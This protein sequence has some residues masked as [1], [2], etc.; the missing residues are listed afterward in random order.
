[1]KKLLLFLFAAIA[2]LGLHAEKVALVANSASYSGEGVVTKLSANKKQQKETVSTDAVTVEFESAYFDNSVIRTYSGKKITITPAAGIKVTAISFLNAQSNYPLSLS[3]NIGSLNNNNWTGE[4]TNAIEF[5]HTTSKGTQARFSVLEITY[6][7]EFSGPIDFVLPSEADV[8]LNEK[9][10]ILPEN[11][12]ANITWT[13]ANENIATVENGVITGISVGST[14][15]TASWEPSEKWNA[16]ST[17][18]KVTVSDLKKFRQV[19]SVD[20]LELNKYYT[21]GCYSASIAASN[22]V[23]AKSILSTPVNFSQN[24]NGRYEFFENDEMLTFSLIDTK[25]SGDNIKY[26]IKLL[27]YKGPEEYLKP[28][29]KEIQ[30][31]TSS[32]DEGY[33][34]I[35]FTTKG[36]VEIK[37]GNSSNAILFNKDQN[38]FRIYATSS[39][40][41]IQL[42]KE[43]EPTVQDNYRPR[44]KDQT[45]QLG[46]Q[47]ST[48]KINLGLEGDYPDVT[49][50]SSDESVATVSGNVVTAKGVGSA[51]ITGSWEES[52]SW[53]A[54]SRAFNVSVIDPKK[55][56]TLTFQHEIIHGKVGVGVAAQAAIYDG[57]GVIT[58]ESSNTSAVTV[59]TKTGMIRPNDVKRV[60]KVFITA[61]ATGTAGT[62]PASA[63]YILY[64]DAVPTATD[65]ENATFDFTKNNYG[66][67]EFT[68]ENCTDENNIEY[69]EATVNQREGV[70]HNHVMI[71]NENGIILN[72]LDREDDIDGYR[73]WKDLAG[74]N[75]DEVIN[76]L[77]LYDCHFSITAP[78]G[79]TLEYIEFTD[80]SDRLGE[81][82][83]DCGSFSP[84]NDDEDAI[85]NAGDKAISS[86]E[87]AATGKETHFGK[88]KVT[89]R[90]NT[91]GMKNPNLTFG[92]RVYS[93]TAGDIVEV[94]GAETV[95]NVDINYSI[96]NTDEN[97]YLIEPEA[98]VLQIMLADPG[99][100][101]L[102]AT[103]EATDEYVAGMAIARIDVFPAISVEYDEN[104]ADLTE[105]VL[106]LPAEGGYVNFTEV[107]GPVSLLVDEN[108]GNGEYTHDGSDFTIEENKDLHLTYTPQYAET[109]KHTT[110]NHLYVYTV[111]AI[112]TY[113]NDGGT[114]HTYSWPEGQEF[115][116]QLSTQNGEQARAFR[117]NDLDGWTKAEGNTLTIDTEDH[118]LAAG[119][120]LHINTKTVKQTINGPIET[121]TYFNMP[122]E[123]GMSGIAGVETDSNADVRYFNLEGVEMHGDLAPGLYIR[124]T[125][126]NAQKVNVK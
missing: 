7:E 29:S 43:I 30:K 100:Y 59:D 124:L 58:Y 40:Q 48:Y 71:V 68:S 120:M 63:S 51:I 79:C 25:T 117:A 11:H 2:T 33:A 92:E 31:S 108:D 90:D 14:N 95:A 86:V 125:S 96:D 50:T 76:Y 121:E 74:E 49:F 83:A 109:F 75:Y 52:D 32:S 112:P 101:T 54:D 15:I 82:S 27:N 13:S 61:N 21:I 88:I 98:N 69:Y 12:P 113:S 89:L 122:A 55:E 45:L 73:L 126:G 65:V 42:Y 116:Y 23:D 80:H 91:A 78:E 53:F 22:D 94:V 81:I 70:D 17:S 62:N 4:S 10:N 35:T 118:N 66:M 19:T 60:G 24:E 9:T 37:L 114:K 102:R 36:N 103:S 106:L 93:V 6:V 5:T 44:W 64:I 1:M 77:C 38:Y 47:Y 39:G 46:N 111:P 34:T 97:D 99:V 57:D 107:G 67:Y 41:V 87:F 123:G 119:Q 84:S 26:L 28:S 16:G 85:W 20:E 18:I 115:Y 104:N 72:F 8:I 105:N 3:C 56:P 110:T